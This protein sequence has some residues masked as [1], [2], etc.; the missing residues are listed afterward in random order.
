MFSYPRC[1]CFSFLS[2]LLGLSLVLS[3]SSSWFSHPPASVCVW[4]A[5]SAHSSVVARH[6]TVTRLHNWSGD[7]GTMVNRHH[8]GGT[9]LDRWMVAAD[10]LTDH[11]PKL[12]AT[13]L[14]SIGVRRGYRGWLIWLTII[15]IISGKYLTYRTYRSGYL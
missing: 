14:S 3:F 8:Q 7:D 12:T 11:E 10:R 5:I 6:H 13:E 1:G 2:S 9:E 4:K 15:A